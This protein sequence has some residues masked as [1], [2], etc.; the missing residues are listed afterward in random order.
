MKGPTT[1]IPTHRFVSSLIWDLPVGRNRAFGS[2]MP[3]ALDMLAGGWTVSSIVQ[4][5]SGS[6]LT[7]FYNSHCGSGTNCYGN[8]KADSVSG[9]DP[10]SGP[11][12]LDQ[13][14]NTGAYSISAF[15]D[16]AGRSIFLGRFGNADK[17]AIIGPGVWN[18]D[19]AAM[20]DFRLGQEMRFGVNVFV[21]NLFN[22]ANWG[23]PETNVNSTNYGRI[24][25]LNTDFPLRRV[26]L[27][28]RLTF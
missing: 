19:F 18:V 17:G 8:E 6:H 4:V 26:V 21:T 1:N 27:G 12:T 15:R 9:Q 25:S 22:H 28:G 14:F 10:N 13:W 7:A 11:K 24:S 16:A 2:G 20:K 5:Q 23:K 3:A